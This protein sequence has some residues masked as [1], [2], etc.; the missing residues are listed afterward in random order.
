V[1]CA[2]NT[3]TR[4]IRNGTVLLLL[5]KPVP[6][7]VF[8]YAK[9]VGVVA[10][11]TVFVFICSAATIISL[12]VAK[13]Q[14]RL[15]YLTFYGYYLMLVLA[16][17][18]GAVRNYFAR[19]SFAASSTFALIALLPAF[20][21]VL[22]LVKVE[23]QVPPFPF[24]LLPALILLFFAIWAMCAITVTLATRLDLTSNLTCAA[25]LFLF[26]LISDYVYGRFPDTSM[27]S[28]TLSGT[29]YA[30]VPNWQF[31]WMAD[32]LAAQQRIP[33]RYI[34]W[35]GLYILLYMAFCSLIAVLLFGGREVGDEPLT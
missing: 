11:L 9:T 30:V 31:F 24:E 26:G 25:L 6:R 29:L 33:W 15:D 22:R 2:A 3:V 4:E 27:V 21:A 32:A 7:W 19:K 17:G 8:I 14:F 34:G 28:R 12:R 18:Y 5:S 20:I 1:L 13:D 16:A 10:A 35:A 23:G